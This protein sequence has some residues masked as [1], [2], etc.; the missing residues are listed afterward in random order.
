MIDQYAAAWLSRIE[1]YVSALLFLA[2]HFVAD[3]VSKVSLTAMLLRCFR[4][5]GG[6]EL[7]LMI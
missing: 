3:T 1:Q 7:S 6:V 5:I 4:H 2:E